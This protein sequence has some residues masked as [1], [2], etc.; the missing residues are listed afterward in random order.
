MFEL[1]ATATF[2]LEAVVRREI[3]DLGYEI[4]KTEDGKVTFA[5]DERALVRSNLWLRCADRVLLKACEFEALEFEDL[6]QGIKSYPWESLIPADGKF[7]VTCSTVKSKLHNPPAIQSVSKKAVVERMRSAYGIERFAET[8]AEY[9][10]KVTMLKDRATVTVDSSGT[11]LHKRGYRVANVDAPMKETLA[12]ALV[13]L[14]F[15]RPGRVLVDPCCGSGTIPIEAAMIAMNIAPGLNR[16]FA[17]EDWSI[18]PRE[19]WKEE[20]K[21]AFEAIT[22]PGASASTDSIVPAGQL[23]NASRIFGGDIDPVAVEAARANAREAGVDG[24]IAFAR[25][26]VRDLE[27]LVKAVK[28]AVTS[29]PGAKGG[30]VRGIIVT[31]PPYG[32]R[33]GINDEIDRIFKSLGKFCKKHPDWSLFIITPDK[34]AEKKIMGR[35]ADRRRKLYNGNIETTYYQFHGAK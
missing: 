11:G 20:R 16:T 25:A 23:G 5:G 27:D 30:D 3:E 12:A 28:P 10:I 29:K 34:A 7:T 33:I 22:Q 14:S 15:F 8:G 32:E 18:I 6:F 35:R 21:A 1:I 2:G 26:D 24:C 13:K 9:T 31:N 17:C 4:I 19:V